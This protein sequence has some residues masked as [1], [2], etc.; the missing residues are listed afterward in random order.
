MA[1]GWTRHLKA[2]LIEP[3]SAGIEARGLNRLAV[4]AMGEAGVDISRQYSKTLG[5]LADNRFDFVI[6]VCDQAKESCPVYPAWAKV[7]HFGFEDPPRLA[8]E[9]HS[10]EEALVHYRRIRDEIRAF[11]EKLPDSLKIISKPGKSDL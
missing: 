4:R 6:T 10:D 2:K 11:V 7:V 9:A 3:F 5:E 8:R 1:E